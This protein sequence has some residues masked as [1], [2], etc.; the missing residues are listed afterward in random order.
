MT[1]AQVFEAVVEMPPEVPD[2]DL[3]ALEE[4]PGELLH[5]EPL[6]SAVNRTVPP[7]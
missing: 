3:P 4:G 5:G 6:H 2:F 1:E 7:S